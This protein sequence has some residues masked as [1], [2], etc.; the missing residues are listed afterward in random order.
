MVSPQR[1][2][3]VCGGGVTSTDSGDGGFTADVQRVRVVC[4]R[5]IGLVFTQ[6]EVKSENVV[7]D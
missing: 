1:H 4:G 2:R 3:Y 6:S 7:V 5:V